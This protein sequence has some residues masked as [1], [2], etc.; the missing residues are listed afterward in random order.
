MSID[1][2]ADLP[3]PPRGSF[4][5][6][7]FEGTR[8]RTAPTDGGP[9]LGEDQAEPIAGNLTFDQILSGLNPLHH[10]PV[11]GMIYRA[12]T[13]EEI[14]P[15]MRVLGGALFGG[16]PGMMLAAVLSA[17]EEFRPAERM[18]AVLKGQPDPMFPDGNQAGLHQAGLHQ[19]LAA[20]HQ[21]GNM[22]GHAA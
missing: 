21:V 17:A 18:V 1:S 14:A 9:P 12:A 11:I 16:V 3:A 2:T 4:S 8:A 6:T 13:G 19:A 5:G 10:L 15:P 22:V 20:Y 7:V